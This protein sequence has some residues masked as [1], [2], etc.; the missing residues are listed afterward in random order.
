MSF[1]EG[2]HQKFFFHLNETKNYKKA[3]I[4]EGLCWMT[5]YSE[6]ARFSMVSIFLVIIF[7]IKNCIYNEYN[8]NFAICYFEHFK[9]KLEK[10]FPLQDELAH[11]LYFWNFQKQNRE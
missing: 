8:L 4:N 2:P 11:S 7:I 10:W 3:K 1:Q 6:L 9:A 5:K